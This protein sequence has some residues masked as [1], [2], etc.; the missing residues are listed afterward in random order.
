MFKRINNLKKLINDVKDIIESDTENTVHKESKRTLSKDTFIVV[1]TEYYL[2]NINKL[3][4]PNP[5][6]KKEN[7]R[8]FFPTYKYNYINKPVRL[9]PEPQ[10]KHDRNAIQVLIAG[11]L[12][13]Y[14]SREKNIHV[15]DI[16]RKAEIKY[17][18]AYIQGG[19]Y[20]TLSADNKVIN[21]EE[22]IR[23]N[24]RIGYVR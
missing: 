6:C 17:I 19:P 4:L 24:V 10:N 8:P 1:G 9:V 12:V 21:N 7:L 3:R 22:V 18:S 20:K 13:G 23:I 15:K 16:F 2:K 11:E 14:I 5:E